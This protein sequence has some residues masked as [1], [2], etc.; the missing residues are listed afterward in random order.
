[1]QSFS[2]FEGFFLT[3][4]C[5]HNSEVISPS[6]DSWYKVGAAGKSLIE[7]ELASG[8]NFFSSSASRFNKI[9]CV[10]DG[11]VKWVGLGVIP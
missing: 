1:M 5:L 2:A 9:G 4:V 11:I 10:L 6:T 7:Q 3:K 8:G